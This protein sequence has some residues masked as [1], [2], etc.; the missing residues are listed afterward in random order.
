LKNKNKEV[1][2]ETWKA[3][4]VLAQNVATNEKIFSPIE[5]MKPIFRGKDNC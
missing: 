5:K 1:P 4:V 3:Y 2:W